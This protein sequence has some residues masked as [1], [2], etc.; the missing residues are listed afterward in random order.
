M[1]ELLGTAFGHRRSADLTLSD[2]FLWEF[3]KER[4]YSNNPR[5]LEEPKHSTEQTVASTDPETLRKVAR[6]T[7]KRVNA[8]LRGGG[9]HFQHLL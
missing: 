6:N 8:C 2:F 3:I 5:S 9:G 7:L 1:S 4:V